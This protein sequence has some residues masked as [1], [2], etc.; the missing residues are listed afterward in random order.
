MHPSLLGAVAFG[1]RLRQLADGVQWLQFAKVSFLGSCGWQQGSGCC[2]LWQWGCSEVCLF[3]PKKLSGPACKRCFK[4]PV[5]AKE[6]LKLVGAFAE[7]NS[8]GE[9]IVFYSFA[10]H[11]TLSDWHWFSEEFLARSAS[12]CA[13]FKATAGCPSVLSAGEWPQTQH[14]LLLPLRCDLARGKKAVQRG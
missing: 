11:R 13:I 10:S 1:I 4:K 12:T 14:F 6:L 3:W 2:L 5:G 7:G 9:V 8:N